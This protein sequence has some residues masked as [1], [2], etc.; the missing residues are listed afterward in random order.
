MGQELTIDRGRTVQSNFHDYPLLRMPQAPPVEVHF[1]RTDNP[2][3]GMGEPALP[4]AVPALCNAI[5]AATG[6]RIRSLPLS[7]HGL[8]WA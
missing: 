6:R 1:L 3:T 7:K 2:P 4:P 5:F 8:R